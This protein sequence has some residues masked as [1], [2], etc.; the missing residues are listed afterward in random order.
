MIAARLVNFIHQMLAEN[1]QQALEA[2]NEET[3]AS[4]EPPYSGLACWRD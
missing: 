4:F 3:I 1:Q 2:N